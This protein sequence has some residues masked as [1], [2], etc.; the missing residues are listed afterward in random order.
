M[1]SVWLVQV[2]VASV[3]VATVAAAAVAVV[4]TLLPAPD[5]IAAVI[6]IVV[7]IILTV[8]PSMFIVI[9]PILV[10]HVCQL[11]LVYRLSGLEGLQRQLLGLNYLLVL[12]DGCLGGLMAHIHLVR[13]LFVGFEL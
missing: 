8:A 10:A 2:A 1:V 11:L 9:I 13:H 3:T 4:A 5:S 6:V 12:L 7:I